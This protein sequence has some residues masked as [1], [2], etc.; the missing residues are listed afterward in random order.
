M[1][2]TGVMGI[3]CEIVG[4]GITCDTSTCEP[5]NFGIGTKDFDCLIL[6]IGTKDIFGS[7][8]EVC[9]TDTFLVG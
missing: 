8:T 1:G 3:I 4:R 7:T 2:F 6:G 9:T 5:G